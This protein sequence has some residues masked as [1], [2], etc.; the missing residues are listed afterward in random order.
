LA[1]ITGEN[2]LSST[3]GT[4]PI[5]Y[6]GGGGFRQPGGDIITIT[7]DPGTGATTSETWSH[8]VALENLKMQQAQFAYEQQQN[9]LSNARAQ[10]QLQLQQQQYSSSLAEQQRQYA[11][12]L[13]ASQMSQKEYESKLAEQ[14]RQFGLAQ[15]TQLGQLG[16]AQAGESRAAALAPYQLTAAQLANQG[17]TLD[18]AKKQAEQDAYNRMVAMSTAN[19]EQTRALAG[20]PLGAQ[21]NAALNAARASGAY[22]PGKTV[23]SANYGQPNTVAINPYLSTGSPLAAF[24][25]STPA[26]SGAG[27]YPSPIQGAKNV[28]SG[29]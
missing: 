28:I 29:Y 4:S 5:D 14:Q 26:P 2:A 12:Q 19:L 3:A 13:A 9:V 22:V 27:L 7:G 25:A 8:E 21:S 17:T 18:I 20:T 10:A 23:I 15:Q 6:E 24:Y 16:I 11:L 1:A